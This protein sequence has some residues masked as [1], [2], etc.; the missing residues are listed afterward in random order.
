MDLDSAFLQVISGT[1]KLE[2]ANSVPGGEISGSLH[3]TIGSLSDAGKLVLA[4]GAFQSIVIN[5]VASKGDP[6]DWVEL[7]NSSYLPVPLHFLSLA[8]DLDNLGKRVTFPV[9]M[10]IDG[11]QYLRIQ[12]DKDGWPGFA[13]GGDEELGVWTSE[14]VLVDSV[15]WDEGHAGE[16]GELRPNPRRDRRF[17]DGRQSHAGGGERARSM[18]EGIV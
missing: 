5:E 17:P 8:D 2:Q 18:T 3:I 7:Y 15:D 16:G 14:G 1:L 9:G 4:S 11:G 6:L 13:L 10:E 12:L